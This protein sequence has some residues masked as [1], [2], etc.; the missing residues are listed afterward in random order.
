MGDIAQME[1]FGDF[2]WIWPSTLGTGVDYD[3]AQFGQDVTTYRQ[4]AVGLLRYIEFTNI[5]VLT[6]PEDDWL[7]VGVLIRTATSIYKSATSAIA[8]GTRWLQVYE[9][10]PENLEE[11]IPTPLPTATPQPIATPQPTAT[12]IP[13][14]SGIVTYATKEI[15]AT[16]RTRW[17]HHLEAGKAFVD[18]Y[19]GPAVVIGGVNYQAYVRLAPGG[20]IGTHGYAEVELDSGF[21]PVGTEARMVYQIEDVTIVETSGERY[22]A[23]LNDLISEKFAFLYLPPE[24][25]VP[26]FYLTT[27]GYDKLTT[28]SGNLLIREK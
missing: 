11:I 17:R 2:E 14:I 8:P 25:L 10:T 18:H 4:Q 13:G 1:E 22:V 27:E 12:P 5:P 9:L 3:S 6:T 23:T 20:T 28:E 21:W 7:H 16:T 24:E 15:F 26:V 19:P